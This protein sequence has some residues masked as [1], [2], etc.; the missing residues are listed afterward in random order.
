MRFA[1][2]DFEA[3]V[4]PFEKCKDKIVD[5]IKEKKKES[6]LIWKKDE[7]CTHIEKER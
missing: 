2:L 1:W 7:F 5:K 4:K 6:G 3:V